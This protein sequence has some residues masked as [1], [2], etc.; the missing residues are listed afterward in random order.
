M[1]TAARS[2]RR[3]K[4][5]LAVGA[6]TAVVAALLVACSTSPPAPSPAPA[7]AGHAY[8]VDCGR[9][10]EGTGTIDRPWSS[11]ADVDSHPAFRPGDRVLLR[12]GAVC[13]GRLTPAGS[14]TN[15]DPIVLGAYGRGPLPTVHGGGT[16]D[17]TG[18]VQLTDQ[19]DWVVQDLEVTNLD[20]AGPSDTLRAGVLVANDTGGTLRGLEIRRMLVRDVTS[21]PT[22]STADPHTYGGIAAVVRGA[23]KAGDGA[24]DDLRI[25]DD[26]VDHVGRTGIAVWSDGPGPT[27]VTNTS[28]TGN[29]LR[30][31]QGDSIIVWGVDGAVIDHNTS[32]HGGDLPACPR[33]SSTP[34]DP[35]SAGIWPVASSH[36]LVRYNDVGDEGS[37]GGDGEGFDIDDLTTDVVLEG[38]HAH[39][40]AGGGLLICGAQDAVVRHN[41]FE[42]DGAGEIVFSC[43]TQRSGV[44]IVGNTIAVTPGA[45]LPVVRRMTTSGTAPILFANDV[46]I[47]P[48]GGGY[49]WPSPVTATHDVFFGAA[50]PTRPVDP[51]AITAD[52]ELVEPGA[53]GTGLD[54]AFVYRP[55]PGSPVIGSGVVTGDEGLTDYA[56]WPLVPGTVDRGAFTGARRPMPSVHGHVAVDRSGAGV[57]LRWPGNGTIVWR[58]L[59]SVDGAPFAAITGELLDPRFD[60]VDAPAGRL[61]YRVVA[62]DRDGIRTI[63]VSGA[64]GTAGG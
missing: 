18:T 58:V 61:R 54:A 1:R 53:V 12:R 8:Y 7:P 60:D 52:P 2:R 46:V 22:Q 48:D 31:I 63:G 23:A 5:A 49:D 40:D 64:T 35:A 34:Q 11:V 21:S 26:T 17:Q 14:G 9:A 50:S 16:P 37:G 20:P 41:V 6:V 45:G 36:V 4:R 59:R 44:R 19:H 39:D 13:D 55:R 62:V 38:N 15:G 29:T 27:R 32:E 10:T 43:P 3:T 56:G 51:D 24:F 25:E 57:L 33:C 42:H 30:Y 47:D 28:I